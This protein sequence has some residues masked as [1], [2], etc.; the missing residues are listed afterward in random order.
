MKFKTILFCSESRD[1]KNNVVFEGDFRYS[2]EDGY[3][4]SVV[5]HH[6]SCFWFY[7]VRLCFTAQSKAVITFFHKV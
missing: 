1:G 4:V 7:V 5:I 2:I 3:G 6:S